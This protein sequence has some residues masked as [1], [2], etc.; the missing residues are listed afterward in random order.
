M[1]DFNEIIKE[2]IHPDY[3]KSAKEIID[4]VYQLD[5]SGEL[6][7]ELKKYYLEDKGNIFCLHLDHIKS[8]LIDK[9]IIDPQKNRF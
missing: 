3:R 6:L 8:L 5:N 4:N 7:T 1:F 2:E 9:G